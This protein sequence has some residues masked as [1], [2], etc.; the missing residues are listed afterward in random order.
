MR[1]RWTV[2]FAPEVQHE[3]YRIPRGEAAQ[4]QDAIAILFDGPT[5]AGYE[6]LSGHPSIFAYERNGYQIWYEVIE[7]ARSIRVLYFEAKSSSD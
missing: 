3:K 4:F 6:P 1:S 2:R 7:E 5:P